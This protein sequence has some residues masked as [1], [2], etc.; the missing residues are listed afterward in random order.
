MRK[1]ISVITG[2]NGFIG[3]H[4]VAYLLEQKHEIKCIIRETSDLKWI[5]D[6]NVEFIKCGLNDVPKLSAA[7]EG[8]T[9]IFHLAGV[10]RA[11]KFEDYIKGNVGLTENV[12]KACEGHSS[13]KKIIVTSSLAASAPAQ[14]DQ[15]VTEET[16]SRPISLY[17]KS[18][19]EMEQMLKKK[20][21]HLPYVIVRPPVVY[22][23]RDTEVLLFFKTVQKG[24]VSK[25]GFG[26]KQVSLVYIDDL[27]RGLFLAATKENAV[28]QTYFFTS[29][30]ML[31]WEEIGKETASILGKK[32]IKLSVP[33][34]AVYIVAGIAEIFSVFQQKA[35]TLN[36]EKAKEM[37]KEAWTCSDEKA[38]KELGYKP[39]V[40][41]NEGFKVTLDWYKKNAWL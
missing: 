31:E 3:S 39:L 25:I 32:T 24:L 35:P 41:L 40:D 5:S 7:F 23:P 16:P 26:K 28:R 19:V 2:A 21:N 9:Y 1:I 37:T 29:H 27:I 15:P 30:R 4:L 11:K 17:G 20:Y 36:L 8:A 18:K 12:F 6:L 14:L 33:H 34:F 10:T 22:G 13:I 38:R